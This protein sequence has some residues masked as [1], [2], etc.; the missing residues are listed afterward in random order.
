MTIL[1]RLSPPLIHEVFFL[2]INENNLVMIFLTTQDVRRP[3]WDIHENERSPSATIFIT[4]SNLQKILG[5]FSVYNF[6]PLFHHIFLSS[7]VPTDQTLNEFVDILITKKW[8]LARNGKRIFLW[9][10]WKINEKCM[11]LWNKV[12]SPHFSNWLATFRIFVDVV[13]AFN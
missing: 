6:L 10:N 7:F 1:D 3:T 12:T 9:K 2:F 5:G 4:S 8:T 13:F 11:N